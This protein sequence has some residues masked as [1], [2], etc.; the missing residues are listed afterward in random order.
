MWRVQGIVGRVLYRW[1][2][3]APLRLTQGPHREDEVINTSSLLSTN[4]HS[5]KDN[6]EDGEERRRKRTSQFYYTGLPRYTAL[7]AVG[8]GAAAVLLMQIC[9]R[10][11]L[12]FTSVGEQNPRPTQHKEPGL[13]RKCGYRIL[14]EIISRQQD[15]TRHVL[16]GA[17]SL[18]RHR[19]A[20]NTLDQSSS[21]SST[22]SE[23]CDQQGAQLSQESALSEESFADASLLRK[24]AK[25]EK[26]KEQISQDSLTPEER[27]TE[28]TE[29]LKHVA[30]TSVPVI[31]N[32]IGLE[33][34]KAGDYEAAFSCF[35]AAAQHRYSK[36][37]FNVGVC[38]EKGRGVQKN[39]N[40][41]LQFYRRAAAAGHMQAQY[42]CAKLL[43]SSRRQQRA[44]DLDTAIT[45]LQ[46]AA[47]AGLTE[48]QLYLG[49]LFS[50]DSTRDEGK[51]VQYL[52]M[53]A[54]SGDSA[55]LLYLGQCY[56]HG[57][58]VN[59][60]LSTAA[61]LYMQ[62]AAAGNQR[63]KGV[64]TTLCDRE[65][66]VLHSIRSAPCF[67]AL[68][69]MTLGSVLSD[70]FRE[71]GPGQQQVSDWPVQPLPHSWSTGSL[72]VP[73]THLY[74]LSSADNAASKWTIGV[75]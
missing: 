18:N 45:L 70:V 14:L 73:P 52:R 64:L 17:L 55:G 22:A 42:R 24:K 66:H 19:G 47:A 38:Y 60:C 50:Q 31:L 71:T 7:D 26:Q 57:I 23:Y 32:I 51:A 21:S 30:D 2:S 16:P 33:S 9:K 62:S 28:A 39:L 8:L 6:R 49:V 3:N 69:G 44:E 15:L 12:Q 27:L 61:N 40:K 4:F 37:Q 29:N 68:D 20:L 5:D 25:P 10:I 43:L 54:Q 13:I 46:S 48:A 58:G 11:H 65:D 75:G 1:H 56:E 41:A 35:L 63:A 72:R 74:P 59:R 34:A 36:A 53:A 67:S